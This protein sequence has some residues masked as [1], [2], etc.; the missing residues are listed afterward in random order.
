MTH[1]DLVVKVLAKIDRPGLTRA[2]EGNM[3]STWDKFFDVEQFVHHA[4]IHALRFQERWGENNPER[5]RCA[6]IGCGFGYVAL[7][8]ECLGHTCLAWDNDA[9]V[10]RAAAQC[11]PVSQR[12]F[13]TI[14]RNDPAELLQTY[15]LI[16]L[17]GV[18]PMRDA[19]G[20]WRW[21]DYE[22]LCRKLIAALNPGGL[23]EIIVNRGDELEMI[24]EGATASGLAVTDNVLTWEAECPAG[25]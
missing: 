2:W 12:N 25:V 1:R 3:G 16:F 11:I 6:D 18:F 13:Q 21:R 24:C 7:A 4:C 17:H 20:W 19:N 8:L 5:K 14:L 15:D 23:L 10:L 9:P 22:A